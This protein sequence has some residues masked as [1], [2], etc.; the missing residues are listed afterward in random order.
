MNGILE[1]DFPDAAGGGTE[2]VEVYLDDS[3]AT[4]VGCTSNEILATAPLD[5][6]PGTTVKLV[7]RA[8]FQSTAPRDVLIR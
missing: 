2:E 4:V 8:G 3:K 7:V 5:L 1:G 6:V